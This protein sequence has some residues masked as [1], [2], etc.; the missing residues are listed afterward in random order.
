MKGRDVF[1]VGTKLHRLGYNVNMV[2]DEYL[3]NEEMEQA[4]KEFQEVANITVDG[5]VGP[6]TYTTLMRKKVV[7]NPDQPSV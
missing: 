1:T 3:Y 5:K 6:L 2:D 4:V 7:I